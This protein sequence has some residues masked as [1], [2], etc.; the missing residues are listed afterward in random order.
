MRGLIINAVI[1]TWED[2]G[3]HNE[4]HDEL[5]NEP[6]R[7]VCDWEGRVTR[8]WGSRWL[9]YEISIHNIAMKKQTRLYILDGLRL[10][11]FSA[12]FFSFLSELLLFVD[13]V[14]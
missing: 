3:P 7:Q 9:K 5:H 14:A 2:I 4:L 8:M 6:F 13:V 12:I 11:S 10:S 1:Y